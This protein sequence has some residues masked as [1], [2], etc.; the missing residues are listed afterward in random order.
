LQ[1][2]ECVVEYGDEDL[3]EL[4]Y[5]AVIP[6]VELMPRRRSEV[7]LT[8]DEGNLKISIEA[9]DVPALRASVTGVLRLVSTVERILGA[10]GWPKI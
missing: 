2:F 9:E 4:V 10:I 6:D 5:D 1:R 3:A 7:D 8:V